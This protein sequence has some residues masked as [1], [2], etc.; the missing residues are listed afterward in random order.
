MRVP[1][2]PF[3]LTKWV[4]N[5]TD[6]R[7]TIAPWIPRTVNRCSA[8]YAY[9][10]SCVDR[11][12]V[13]VIKRGC[14]SLLVVGW[15]TDPHE[16]LHLTVAAECLP[17]GRVSQCYV[18]IR[19]SLC[20]QFSWSI[21]KQQ[22]STQIILILHNYV[23]FSSFS[24]FLIN[25]H[26]RF[27]TPTQKRSWK[28]NK[29]VLYCIN[30]NMAKNKFLFRNSHWRLYTTLARLPTRFKTEKALQRAQYNR[31]RESSHR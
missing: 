8:P 23:H 9:T 22:E 3:A 4:G 24:T 16:Q 15:L 21:Y 27:K 20:N 28:K 18:T 31:L 12:L 26:N 6:S 5:W 19:W 30:I 1:F 10:S 17:R 14:L 25:C 11:N 29:A 2:L 7:A 13:T